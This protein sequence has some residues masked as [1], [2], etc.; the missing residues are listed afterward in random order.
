MF[1]FRSVVSVIAVVAGLGAAHAA[2]LVGTERNALGI[3]D[4]IVDGKSYDVVFDTRSLNAVYPSPTQTFFSQTLAYD[5]V[6]AVSSFFNNNGV[7]GIVDDDTYEFNVPYERNNDGSFSVLETFNGG[8]QVGGWEFARVGRPSGDTNYGH[9]SVAVFSVSAVPLP[10]S[11]P[12]FGAALLAFGAVGYGV[13]R[14]KA[15]AAV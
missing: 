1:A 4:L 7:T 6:T 3:N 13:R 2:T 12:M 8:H 9:N 14:K 10:A 5:A 11:A 15:A